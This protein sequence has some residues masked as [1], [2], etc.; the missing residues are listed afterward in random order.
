[1]W[2]PVPTKFKEFRI[3]NLIKNSTA[4]WSRNIKGDV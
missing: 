1:M 2:A 3:N 4:A